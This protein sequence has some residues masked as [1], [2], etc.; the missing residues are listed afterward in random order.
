MFCECQLLQPAS[1][2]QEQNMEPFL[3]IK[4]VDK[5]KVID[6]YVH[7]VDTFTLSQ[8]NDDLPIEFIIVKFYDDKKIS[9]IPF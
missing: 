8:S 7:Y 1:V 2:S 3:I 4:S 5:I 6:Y 9:V